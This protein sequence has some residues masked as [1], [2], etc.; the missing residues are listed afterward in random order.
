[1]KGYSIKREKNKQ[2]KRYKEHVLSSQVDIH[3]H[4]LVMNEITGQK[5]SLNKL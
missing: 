4:M 3:E 2:Y 5:F 1:M